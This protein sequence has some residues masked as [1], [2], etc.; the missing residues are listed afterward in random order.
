MTRSIT[1]LA[2]TAALLLAS[3]VAADPLTEGTMKI[4]I[5]LD[6]EPLAATLESSAAARDFAALLPLDLTLGDYHR[7]EKVADLPKRLSTEG[8]PEGIDPEIGDIAYFAPWG[9]LAIFYRDFG[10]SRGLV[11]LGRIDGDVARL[12]A[13]PSFQARIERAD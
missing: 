1:L 6:G 4:R 8:A 5:I 10:Y 11:R 13:K 9:N 7:T 2:A 12:A 3:P